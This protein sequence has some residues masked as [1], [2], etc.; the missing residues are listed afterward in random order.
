MYLSKKKNTRYVDVANVILV[1]ALIFRKTDKNA[2][3][4]SA[5]EQLTILILNALGITEWQL[6]NHQVQIKDQMP[7]T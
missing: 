1:S 3:A 6:G 7:Y 4:A 5:F 2:L